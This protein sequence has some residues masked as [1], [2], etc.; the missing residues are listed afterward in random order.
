MI[1][2]YIEH[3]IEFIKNNYSTKGVQYCAE[4][5][6]ISIKR[7]RGIARKYKLT[8]SENAI[9]N[10]NRKFTDEQYDIIKNNYTEYGIDYCCELSGLSPTQISYIA[11]KFKLYRRTT[12]DDEYPLYSEYVLNIDDPIK[13]YCLGLIWTD[14]HIRD[15][16]ITQTTTEPDSSYYYDKL[17]HLGKWGTTRYK[18]SKHPSWKERVNFQTTNP[19]LCKKLQDLNFTDKTLGFQK[20]YDTIPDNF[21][22]FFIIGLIDGDG[23][24]YINEKKGQYQISICSCYEQDWTSYTNILDKLNIKFNI[25]KTKRSSGSYS[26]VHITGKYEVMKFGQFLYSTYEVD[27]IGL[28][29]KYEKYLQI[30]SKCRDIIPENWNQP[31][32]KL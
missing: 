18:H 15:T 13:A 20:V 12:R 29:R 11:R 21:K 1:N 23:C 26:K 24:I 28:P 25:E 22:R 17:M 14:G 27:N 10:I 32:N 3:E 30:L 6:Q 16:T 19:F 8:L 7:V 4:Q 2:K 9:K 31:K 5:L